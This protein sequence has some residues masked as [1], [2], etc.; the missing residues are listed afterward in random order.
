M[1]FRYPGA[2]NK[3]LRTLDPFL[4]QVLRGAKSFHDV[5]TGGGSVL[6]D[7]AKRHPE[8][9]LYAND[10]ED[11]VAAFWKVAASHRVGELCDRLQVKPT[12][13]R[14]YEVQTH[15][16]TSEI[17]RAF[18][19]VFLN[20]TAFS[21]LWHNNPQGGWMQVSRS[22]AFTNWMGKELIEDIQE[23]HRLLKGRLVVTS[24]DGADYV[25]R[26]PNQPKFADPPYFARGS[27]L[28]CVSGQSKPAT[29]GRMKT[30]HF[31]GSIAYWAAWASLERNERTQREL[32]AFDI[33]FGGQRLVQPADCA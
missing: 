8:I 12:V 6:L 20:R 11:H 32:A 27:E 9:A 17:G 29:K 28:Y 1:I 25:R 5:F 22:R 4:S 33:N 15:R 14:F 7:V 2:K 19:F 23:A 26:H 30:S 31:E 13:D 18:K 10:A 21:G 24:E 16:P 3:L